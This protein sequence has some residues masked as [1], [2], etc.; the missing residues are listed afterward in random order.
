MKESR[1]QRNLKGA[2]FVAALLSMALCLG[3]A[4][5][6]IKMP[7]PGGWSSA[8]GLVPLFVSVTMFWMATGLLVSAIKKGGVSTTRK[9][10][11][12]VRPT[13]FLTGN[14]RAFSIIVGTGIYIFILLNI[15]P[16]EPASA[17]Y[18]GCILYLFW[19]GKPVRIAI[20]SL[21]TPFIVS[22]VFGAM[23][24]LLIPGGSVLDLLP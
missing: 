14:K 8:P 7:R 13:H 1:E 10:L 12:G 21:V 6:S 15:M 19:R 4:Y 22:F 16:F 2:D 11:R 23:F 9:Y 18:L 24:H 3:V 20:I 17:L 5:L